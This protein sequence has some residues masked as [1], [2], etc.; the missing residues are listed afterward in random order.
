MPCW[1]VIWNGMVRSD[2]F[3]EIQK[4][5]TYHN[6][7]AWI[8]WRNTTFS[9]MCCSSSW[10]L[11]QQLCNSEKKRKTVNSEKIYFV[12]CEILHFAAEISRWWIWGTKRLAA[13]IDVWCLLSIILPVFPY[14]EIQSKIKMMISIW[15]AAKCKMYTIKY[16]K[17]QN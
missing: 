1:T 4:H 17:S 13:K 10:I 15:M 2:A 3:L 12:D 5:K 11:E 6:A 16:T 14:K 8:L 7:N 9:G